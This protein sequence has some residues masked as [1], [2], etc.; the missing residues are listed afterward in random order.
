[1]EDVLATYLAFFVSSQTQALQ[2]YSCNTGNTIDSVFDL[3]NEMG[4]YMRR[5]QRIELRAKAAADMCGLQVH[6]TVGRLLDGLADMVLSGFGV[7]DTNEDAFEYDPIRK[8]I[9]CRLPLK[10]AADFRCDCSVVVEHGCE[11]AY[12]MHITFENSMM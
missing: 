3:K 7:P 10:D 6:A 5:G 2:L 11:E 4:M 1:M 12:A 9:T 8:H